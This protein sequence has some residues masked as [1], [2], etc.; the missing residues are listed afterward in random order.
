M[1]AGEWVGSLGV[2]ILL[3]AFA[4]NVFKRITSDSRL[5]L[6]MNGLGALLAGI[7]AFMIK[8]WPFVLLEGVWAM[9]SFLLLLK[10]RKKV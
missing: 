9:S 2:G 6:L 3:L 1:T 4:M 10:K 8:F 7:S 5:Y